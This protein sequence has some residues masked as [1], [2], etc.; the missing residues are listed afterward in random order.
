M[1]PNAIAAL[2]SAFVFQEK[3]DIQLDDVLARV[4][5]DMRAAVGVIQ[6]HAIRVAVGLRESVHVKNMSSYRS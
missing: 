3:T 1:E 6:T 4:K 5:P 2:L